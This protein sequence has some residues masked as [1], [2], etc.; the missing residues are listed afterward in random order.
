MKHLPLLLLPFS[1]LAACGGS[2]PKSDPKAIEMAGR[3]RAMEDSLFEHMALD[4]RGAQALIDVYKAY[5]ANFPL[6]TLTPEYL[7]RAATVARNLRDPEQS[8]FLYDRII[9]D[10]PSWKRIADTHYLRAFTLDSDLGRKGEAET[11]YREVIF[12]F[13]DH[14]FARDAR[15]MIENLQYTDEELIA[16]F[17]A[18]E[19]DSA[20]AK[21]GR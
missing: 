6:D 5:A 17:K 21:A 7:F 16:R 12:K 1:I 8:I 15:I 18:M 3:I 10:Y 14:P 11:A 20:T 19:Q 13:P 2:G 4:Q 9:R